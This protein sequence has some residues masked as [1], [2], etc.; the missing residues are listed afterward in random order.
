[1]RVTWLRVFRKGNIE[2][3]EGIQSGKWKNSSL[4]YTLGNKSQV[5]GGSG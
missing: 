5:K 3:F 2:I 1:M 4:G